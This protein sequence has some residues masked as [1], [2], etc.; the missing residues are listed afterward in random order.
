LG[1]YP[2]PWRAGILAAMTRIVTA[3]LAA[4]ATLALAASPAMAAKGEKRA[5]TKLLRGTVWTSY[6]S[7]N[8]TGASLDRTL[9]LC[10]DNRYSLPIPRPPSPARGA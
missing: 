7:G 10:R 6:Q 3:L 2:R 8:V 4:V 9:T 1:A 5:A